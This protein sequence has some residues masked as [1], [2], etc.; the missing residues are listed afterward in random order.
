MTRDRGTPREIDLE[1][2]E[3][4]VESLDVLDRLERPAAGAAPISVAE[5]YAYATD[6]GHRPRRKFLEALIATPRLRDDLRHLL[7]NMA[8]SRLP[9]VAAASSG[10]IR[11]RDGDGCRIEF[12]ASRADPG[13]VYVI[14]SLAEAAPKVPTTL[15][16]Y[17]PQGR[18]VKVPLPEVQDGRIQLLV[19]ADSDLARGLQ[20]IATE[21]YLS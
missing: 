10:A 9:E 8:V 6:P 15:I 20:D 18:C 19:D 5:L 16:V 21:V 4:V 3:R 17:D 7:R 14:I 1:F 11:S 13:Q 2:T 12:R